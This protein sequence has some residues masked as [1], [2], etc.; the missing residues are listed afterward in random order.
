MSYTEYLRRKAATSEKIV[1]YQPRKVD[2]SQFITQQR[3]SASILFRLNGREGVINNVSDPSST[4]TTS[5]LKMPQGV[6]KTAGGHVPDA[7]M[8]T[9]YLGGSAIGKDIGGTSATRNSKYVLPANVPA[10]L[11]TTT[12]INGP[13]APKSAGDWTRSQ[14]PCVN[15]REPHNANELGPSLFVDTTIRL[16]NLTGCCTSDLAEAN[17]T[18]PADVPHNDRWAPRPVHG[19]G[20][21]PVSTISSPSDARKV[22]NRNPRKFAYVEKHHGNDLRVNP[23]RVPTD[24]VP[25][26]GAP[27]HMKINDPRHYPVA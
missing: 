3:L 1:D 24:F 15:G 4:G 21:I 14:G 2:A 19:M 7:S 18:H 10:T 17:H 13:A 16:K 12:F 26:N 11:C 23:R 6:T 27:A 9:A 20:G 22:G 25:T 8:Y 5:N